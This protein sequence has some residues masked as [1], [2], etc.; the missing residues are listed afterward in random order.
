MKYFRKHLLSGIVLGMLLSIWTTPFAAQI[1]M[2]SLPLSGT[3]TE[4]A[5]LPLASG[6]I[7]SSRAI[8]TIVTTGTILAGS[9]TINTLTL[10][11]TVTSGDMIAWSGATST[12]STGSGA[13]A[14]H[15]KA[16]GPI[17][18][19]KQIKLSARAVPAAQL[20]PAAY[21]QLAMKIH[22]DSPAVDEARML[23]NLNK[24]ELKIYDYAK[25]DE[26]LYRQALRQGTNVRWVWKPMR[27]IDFSSAQNA[28]YRSNVEPGFGFLFPLV[29]AKAIPARVLETA[30]SV[31]EKMPDAIFLVSDYEVI[32]PDPFLAVTT[33]K[34]INQNK[35][36]IID[37][38]AE[39]GFSDVVPEMKLGPVPSH[40]EL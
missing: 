4:T 9:P 38:W 11:S 7:T 28:F 24:L 8:G 27:D 31:L 39:P 26:Y 34:L 23:D 35:L 5:V 40:Q 16:I 22:L 25:V 17:P 18:T 15:R 19:L 12:W 36:W 3:G 10:P 1:V 20:A 2:N 30:A 33:K 14:E 29:Y 37:V 21:L 32:R 13:I 6:T